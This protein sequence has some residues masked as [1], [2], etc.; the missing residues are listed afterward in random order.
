MGKGDYRY[1]LAAVDVDASGLDV[2]EQYSIGSVEVY[3]TADGRYMVREP[4]VDGRAE[5]MY[6]AIMRKIDLGMSLASTEDAD[7]EVMSSKFEDAFWETAGRLNRLDEARRLFPHISYFI[8]R[9]LVGYG[10]L[11]TLMRD[12]DIEDIL[13]SAH[14]RNITVVHKR[15]SG[16]FHAL[17]TNIAFPSAKDMERFI[18]RTFGRTG[19]EPTESKPISVTYMDDG[20]RI[21]AT[22]GSQV[23]KPGPIIAI[24]KFPSQPLTITHMIMSGTISAEMAAYLWTLLD[25]KA[26]GLVIGVTGSG[27]TT[28][29]SSLVSMMNPRWRILTIEDTLELQIPHTDWVRYNTRKSYGMLSSGYDLTMRDLI[30]SSLTQ[31]PDYEIIGEIRLRDMDALFQS[32]GTGHGGLTSFHASTPRGALTRMR[33]NGIS[34]GELALLWFTVHSRVVHVGGRNVRRIN[35]ISE[36]T[37][38]AET[39]SIGVNTVFR[40]DVYGDGFTMECG[41]D[42][43]GGD[44]DGGSGSGTDGEGRYR[45]LKGTARYREA[46]LL[47]GIRDPD[48]DMG[49]RIG[50]LERCVRE[51]ATDMRSV[52]GILGEYYAQE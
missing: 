21:S 14:G 37:A 17:E 33:G 46:M 29:L 39:G 43:D 27:K 42:G 25:A 2:L 47:S 6:D 49:K 7:P 35:D 48:E 10:V 19:T 4:R 18:Q 44:G 32:V 31:R 12:P 20:S 41:N 51:K 3:V 50:L 28:L 34:D 22:F 23:T 1:A 13:C 9:E 38:D 5:A 45:A 26:V 8:R 40:Y 11:D 24:R 52:F 15:H 36:I 30:D 16:R